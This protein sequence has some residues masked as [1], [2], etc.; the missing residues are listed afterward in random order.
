MVNLLLFHG[1]SVNSML[2][3]AAYEGNKDMVDLLLSCGIDVNLR[4]HAG[5]IPLHPAVRLIALYDIA[6]IKGVSEDLFPIMPAT[7]RNFTRDWGQAPSP[8]E[9]KDVKQKTEITESWRN[10]NRCR[11]YGTSGC[12]FRG[13]YSCSGCPR[14]LRPTP[15]HGSHARTEG[16][17]RCD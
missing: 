16:N 1:A 10:E 6:S 12:S 4:D 17:R 14:C 7:I 5:Q 13:Y 2:H 15:P 11:K 8:R 9:S 3:K